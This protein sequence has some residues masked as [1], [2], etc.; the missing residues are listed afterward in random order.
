MGSIVTVLGDINKSRMEQFVEEIEVA[1]LA[2]PLNTKTPSSAKF[3]PLER[4]SLPIM[5]R[6]EI[7]RGEHHYT[8]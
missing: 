7:V 8:Y 5:L 2:P 3:S 6:F 4:Q 1:S